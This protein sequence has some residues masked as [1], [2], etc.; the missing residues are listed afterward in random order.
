MTVRARASGPSCFPTPI[1]PE[2]SESSVV[3]G[4]ATHSGV[5]VGDGN[6][7]GLLWLWESIWDVEAHTIVTTGVVE[8]ADRAVI[9]VA[10]I[11]CPTARFA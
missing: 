8:S 2:P 9:R 1:A 4:K 3:D 6:C 11:S 5:F 10:G 7:S